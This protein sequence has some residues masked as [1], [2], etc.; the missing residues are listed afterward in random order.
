MCTWS[1]APISLLFVPAR[2]NAGT[3]EE[4]PT[5]RAPL[6][7]TAVRPLRWFSTGTFAQIRVWIGQ[8]VQLAPPERRRCSVTSYFLKTTY[9]K[10]EGRVRKWSRRLGSPPQP[11][12]RIVRESALTKGEACN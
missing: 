5:Q 1:S 11:A 9:E 3:P 4:H 2:G 10:G 12:V 7:S 6:Q 8:G